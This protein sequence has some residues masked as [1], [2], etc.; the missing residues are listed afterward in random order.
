MDKNMKKT[1]F[2]VLVLFFQSAYIF[3]HETLSFAIVPQQSASKL[4]QLWGPII[5]QISEMSGV[6][7]QFSTAP[8]I[9][10]FEKRLALG[11]YDI[12]YMNP[13][14][15]VV[16]HDSMDYQV[17]A[18]ASNK[19]I[20]GILVVA[21]DSNLFSLQDLKKSTLAFPAPASFA[22]TILTQSALNEQ[23]VDYTAKYVSS[24]DSVY[25]TVAKGIYPAGGGVV[26]TFKNIPNEISDKLRILWTTEGYTPHA[27]AM[28]P[29]VDE[30][31][32][33]K[34][35]QAIIKLASTPEGSKLL[36]NIKISAFESAKNSDWDDIRQLKIQLLR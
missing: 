26:R 3:A 32:K 1:F 34:V 6:K 35:Q 5:N 23:Q 21:K 31:T 11:Q 28:H 10:T 19:K 15:Y 27:I 18:K 14:H 12:A 13:Y 8:D 4:A 24:H 2:L 17:I 7:I 9:P 36:N 22:A 29:R 16:F 20:K 30:L 25:R 33:S